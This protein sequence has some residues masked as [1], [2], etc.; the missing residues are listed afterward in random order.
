M[1][2]KKLLS[3]MLA[4]FVSLGFFVQGQS[5]LISRMPTNG[6]G[7]QIVSVHSFS[8]Q[9][10]P[11]EGATNL[12]IPDILT[13]TDKWCDASTAEPW[14][15]FE[16]SNIYSLDKFVITD[17]QILEPKNGNIAEYKIFVT[18]TPYDEIIGGW[19][20]AD[21]T[22]VAHEVEAGD[23]T[24]KEVILDAAVDARYVKFYVIDKGNRKDNGNYEN[25]IRVY[26]F[27]MYGTFASEIDRG[28]LISVGKTILATEDAVSKRETGFNIIDG[29]ITN[30]FDKWCFGSYGEN[31]NQRYTIIDLE[32]QYDFS[33]I[34]LYDANYLE[35]GTQ[36]MQGCNIYVSD[37]APDLSLINM[38]DEDTNDCWTQVVESNFEETVDVKEYDLTGYSGRFVKVEIPYEK[39]GDVTGTS[40]VFEVEVYGTDAVV[41]SNNANLSILSVSEGTLSPKFS[42]DVT[43]YTVNVDKETEGLTISASATSKKATVTGAGY[44]ELET[45]D[46]TFEV[47][48]L[49]EDGTTSM[50]YIV[51]VNRAEK[52]K[53]STLETLSSSIGYFSP[54]FISDSLN[55]FVDVP[56]GT[57]SIELSA[58]ATQSGATIEGLGVKTLTAEDGDVVNDANV[59]TVLVTAEDGVVT[60]AYTVTV[61]IQSEGLISVNYGLP[62]GKRI[63]NIHSYSAKA[64]D[65]ESPYKLLIGERLNTNGNT[66]NKWCDNKTDQ[67]WVIFSLIDI[68]EINRIVVRD[69][70]LIEGDNDNV[71]NI[72]GYKIEVSTTGVGPD[73]WTVVDED[74]TDGDNILDID[75]LA[76]NAR[77]IRMTFTK[78]LREKD[79]ETAGAVWIYGVDIYGTFVEAVDNNNVVSRGKT[80]VD[81]SSYAGDRETPC[82]LLDGNIRYEKE[83]ADTY[84]I[85]IVKS[86]PWAF[87]VSKGDAWVI[88]DLEN[89]Y[90]VDSFK[91]Y[92]NAD[93][94]KGYKVSV[95]TTGNDNDW[96]E[97]YSGTFAP[98]SV[99]VENEN[100]ELDTVV[101]GPDP[102]IGI[103]ETPVTARFVKLEI[104][105]DMQSSNW[106]RIREFEVYGDVVNGLGNLQSDKNK[107]VVYPNPVNAGD[108]LYLNESGD[109]KIYNLQGIVV[110]DKFVTGATSISTNK[111]GLG[112]YIIQLS[113]ENGI[114]QS[115]LV[116]K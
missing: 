103:L 16:L 25:A 43:S 51:V 115:K 27:D 1:K 29:N 42:G 38:Y 59:F 32:G 28:N 6:V 67:P 49:A 12:L 33:K 46:N 87:N 83:N 11:N 45:G 23:Q 94:I 66:G 2:T 14:V 48:V 111:L 76:D 30:K 88:L 41:A 68:Y 4:M 98:D 114:K 72:G 60:K 20:D 61:D 50:K 95:N 54:S 55:Y 56:F 109:L 80:I 26:G 96:T 9:T 104:P 101:V 22:E 21:W 24:I 102:K 63:V 84:E 15:V 82:N 31:I 36:N 79:G 52:S 62:T 97:V 34:K 78:G 113:N 40:R 73:D 10:N 93:W 18:T 86:D 75:Y 85:E 35:A 37:F 71:A 53:I 13:T 81:A 100:W 69:G 3:L 5:S 39:A 74:W 107:L 77:Y 19:E 57:E 108:G 65:N 70:R 92:D 47:N 7:K 112:S 106:N 110:F 17:A 99:E 90:R 89:E 116:V 58:T 44:K 105:E 8:A 91:V 64:N